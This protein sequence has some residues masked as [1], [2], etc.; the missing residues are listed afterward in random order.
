MRISLTGNRLAGKDTVA[1][2]FAKAGVPVF[3]AD[4]IIKFILNY[5]TDLEQFARKDK[6]LGDGI[7]HQG[8][9]DPDK[10]RTSEQFEKLLEIIEFDLFSAYEKWAEK[11]E[12]TNAYTIF[13]SSI[14]FE[15]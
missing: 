7:F 2:A 9:I 14:I 1:N 10:I 13:H 5:R 8:F 15:N 12:K 4:P 3:N 6:L 11:F